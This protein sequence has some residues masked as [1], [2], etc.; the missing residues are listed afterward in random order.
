MTAASGTVGVEEREKKPVGLLTASFLFL[1]SLH[2]AKISQLS[3]RLVN[4]EL[5]EVAR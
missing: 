4:F 5:V 1:L 3:T 2:T